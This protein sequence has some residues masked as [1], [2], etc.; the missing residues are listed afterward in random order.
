MKTWTVIL[1]IAL[2]SCS[3]NEQKAYVNHSTGGMNTSDTY[4]IMWNNTHISYYNSE[5]DSLGR[6]V[7][8]IT[9]Q[10]N[11]GYVSKDI[12]TDITMQKRV[13]AKVCDSL[14]RRIN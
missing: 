8:I 9:D 3:T 10:I 7:Y 14:T 12:F 11:S 13:L 1:F 2:A 5:C 6:A 4:N